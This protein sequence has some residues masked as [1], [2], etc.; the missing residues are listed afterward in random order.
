MG[1]LSS[2][3]F[4]TA[5]GAGAMYFLDPEQGDQRQR[6]MRNQAIR[7]QADAAEAVNMGV[8]DLRYRT[9]G[10]LAEGMAMVSE[11]TASDQ[12]VA[13][14]IRSRLGYLSRH[15]GAVYVDVQ[16][17]RAVLHGDVL[18]AE[19]DSLLSGVSHIRGVHAVENQLH[20]HENA[21]NIP[22]LQGEGWLPKTSS[23]SAQW[24]PAARLLGTVGAAYLFLYGVARG[25][26]TGNLMRMGGLALGTRA[27]TN[28][29]VRR[30]IGATQDEETI[31]VRKAIYID[32][33]VEQVYGLW[34]NFEN[35]PQFM[36]HV[37]EIQ[38]L[39]EG[40]SHWIVKG[41]AGSKVEFDAILTESRP[42]ELIAWETVENASVKHKGQV[43][44]RQSD[45]NGTHVHVNMAYTPP[46]GIIGHV[47]ASAFAVDPKSSMNKD[48]TRMK[49]ILE[50]NRPNQRDQKSAPKPSAH[51]STQ[52]DSGKTS[53]D[54]STAP[55]LTSKDSPVIPRTGGNPLSQPHSQDDLVSS[56]FQNDVLTKSANPEFDDSPSDE[57]R[58]TSE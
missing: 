2:L 58:L 42:N 20:V 14:R 46:A 6:K 10:I 29:D 7:L 4:G 36:S 13:E 33:P 15:P 38:D 43:R 25:G 17:R 26:L 1:K 56:S 28:L 9:R 44:F 27:L 54:L 52:R 3:L 18:A 51:K 5:L 31:R 50:E 41:P 40:R 8:R 34:S 55:A 47:V 12:M 35:F 21:G 53:S 49:S 37:D 11:D 30:L 22:Q 57:D 32:A 24:S 48:L 45:Q 23:R 16:N 19:L 39:G